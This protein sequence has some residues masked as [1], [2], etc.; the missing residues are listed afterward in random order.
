VT[1]AR[2]SSGNRC[3]H[4]PRAPRL[5]L[6]IEGTRGKPFPKLVQRFV[7]G[8]DSLYHDRR[9]F[10]EL[11][12]RKRSERIEAMVLVGKGLARNTDRL[13]LRAGRR[14]AD[15][16][17]VGITAKT[18]AGWGLLELTKG[19]RGGPRVAQRVYRALWD[20]RDAG[21]LTLTQP[22]ERRRDGSRRGLAGVRQWTKRIFERFG[23]G[24]RLRRERSALWKA[25]RA[26]QHVETI[27]ERKQLRRLFRESARARALTKRTTRQLAE[28]A[29]AE[30]LGQGPPVADGGEARARAALLE[31]Q[32]RVNAERAGKP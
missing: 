17:F 10:P 15:G 9:L 11:G 14:L 8:W 2:A 27:A 26:R 5:A 19:K 23:L 29:G 25:D 24:Q 1:T 21:Y 18:L 3:G 13:T 7:D 16:S 32:R 22:I 30:G 4:D 31:L 20:L 12:A 28:R 6:G